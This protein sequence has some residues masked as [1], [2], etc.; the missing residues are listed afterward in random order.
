MDHRA[1]LNRRL[2]F[3]TLYLAYI[4]AGIISILPGPTLSLLAMHSD[5][6]IRH[7]LG[8]GNT[9]LVLPAHNG[10]VQFGN[11]AAAPPVAFAG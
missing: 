11:Q 4:S 2:L 7:Q 8:Y 3:Y 6:F 1:A 10:S 9:S 5:P